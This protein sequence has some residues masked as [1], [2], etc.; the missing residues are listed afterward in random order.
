MQQNIVLLD[1]LAE[2]CG[3]IKRH[4]Y[5]NLRS[6]AEA[7]KLLCINYPAFKEYLRTSHLKG[8]GYTVVQSD[9]YLDYDEM[10]LPLGSKDLVITPVLIGSG[11]AIKDIGK[12]V[13]KHAS[14]LI[15]IVIGAALVAIGALLTPIMPNVGAAI[16]GAG[17]GMIIGG[18][19][20]IL[21]PVEDPKKTPR[22]KSGDSTST[23]GPQSVTRGSD[24][25]PSY[26]YAGATNNVGVG[27][28]VPL[29]YGQALIGSHLASARIEV[30]DDSDPLL[31]TI[32]EPGFDT[33]RIGGDK[34][35]SRFEK[36]D[37]LLTRSYRTYKRRSSEGYNVNE[38]VDLDEG[39]RETL[40]VVR[41]EEPDD[42]K[43]DVRKF[44]VLFE[45]PNGLF[46]L[47]S[48]PNSTKVHG[49]VTYRIEVFDWEDD[50][51][52]VVGSIQGT[53]SGLLMKNQNYRWAHQ[54]TFQKVPGH[55]D[56]KVKIT[57]IDFSAEEDS[58]RSGLGF[59]HYLRV[60]AMGYKFRFYN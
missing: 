56:Y 11:K 20:G 13:K 49:F 3:G 15:K 33:V 26:A 51:K 23:D 52:P 6:A 17:I 29:C 16:M 42:N 19:V 47:V 35:P 8:V 44:Q 7:I 40:G 14:N 38:Y 2:L 32:Q 55:D 24:G 25:R 27:A 31:T 54:F 59:V 39:D 34:V 36:L 1:E 53:I 43:Y 41:G 30:A 58:G 4:T 10:L 45:L 12:W 18:V 50:S 9:Q 46:K 22:Y 60:K 5:Y 37:G 28:T 57:I 21:S 48:G